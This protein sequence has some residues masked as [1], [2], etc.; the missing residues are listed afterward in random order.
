MKEPEAPVN[1][2]G[3]P[4]GGVRSVDAVRSVGRRPPARWNRAGR[5]HCTE[6]AKLRFEIF[7]RR[8]KRLQR[9]AHVAVALGDDVIKRVLVA[10]VM[11]LPGRH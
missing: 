4:A 7:V 6:I 9:A 8:E 3:T 10:V 11:S 5:N 2:P 1:V